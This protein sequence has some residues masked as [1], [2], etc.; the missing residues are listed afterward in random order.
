MPKSHVYRILRSGEVRANGKRIDPAYRLL[1]GDEIRIPP[2]RV[3]ERDPGSVGVPVG[4]PFPVRYEDEA[5]IALD[6]PAGAAVLGA[7]A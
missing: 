1:A 6:K 2:I 4:K 5:L 3:A 7:A